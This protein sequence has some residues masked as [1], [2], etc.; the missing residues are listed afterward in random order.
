MRNSMITSPKGILTMTTIFTHRELI[1]K[2][3]KRLFLD[4]IS[5]VKKLKECIKAR[6]DKKELSDEIFYKLF[7]NNHKQIYDFIGPH[8]ENRIRHFFG[9]FDNFDPRDNQITV[10]DRFI[11]D[12]IHFDVIGTLLVQFYEE[13]NNN[14]KEIDKS[15]QQEIQAYAHLGPIPNQ[16]I[17]TNL[18][19]SNKDQVF[20][21]LEF[22]IH[23]NVQL[24]RLKKS[25]IELN[26]QVFIHWLPKV[27]NATDSK[28][29]FLHNN[30]ILYSIVAGIATVALAI[31]IA[32]FLFSTGA[33]TGL[34]VISNP[35]SWGVVFGVLITT[36]LAMNVI[37]LAANKPSNPNCNETEYFQEIKQS[38][39]GVLKNKMCFRNDKIEQSP[40]VHDIRWSLSNRNN[41][42]KE[43]LGVSQEFKPELDPCVKIRR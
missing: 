27:N 30:T 38:Y 6:Y 26:A 17:I 12:S 42:V 9:D 4:R 8:N 10:L 2:E 21:D 40:P 11:L 25:S 39:N 13:Y 23:K 1:D 14:Q 37:S 33:A 31:I 19:K 28:S 34:A 22:P 24:F 16:T 32:P 36:L 3:Y 43:K 20:N 41:H 18:I 15:W 29:S 5:N 35:V 7:S